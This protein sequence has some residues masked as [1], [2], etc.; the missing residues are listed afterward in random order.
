[1]KKLFALLLALT[2]VLGLAACSGSGGS[3]SAAAPAAESTAAE[4][5]GGDAAASTAEGG[6]GGG[7]FT[8]SGD[9]VKIGGLINTD[10]LALWYADKMGYFEDEGVKVD[11][12]Y[13]TNGVLENEALAAG[14]VSVGFNGFAGVYALATGDYKLIGDANDGKGLAVY[15]QPD[16]P[17]VGVTGEYDPE[18]PDVLGNA[19]T[20]SGL[21]FAVTL[22]TIQQ[23]MVDAYYQHLGV[24]DY[25]LVSMDNA[26]AFNA[27]MAGE[28]DGAAL[29]MNMVFEAEL[30]GMK[31]L[32][33][34]EDITGVGTGSSTIIPTSYLES[35]YND[36]VLVTRAFY[37]ALDELQKDETLMFDEGMA[38]FKEM[39][40][41]YTED[42]MNL[43]IETRDLFTY[44]YMENDLEFGNHVVYSAMKLVDL[45]L[46][47]PG[48]GQIV[49]DSIDAKVLEDALGFPI[50][51]VVPDGYA[52]Y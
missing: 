37:R 33:T 17:V 38:Y 14:E 52:D 39:G 36:V 4:S 7:E 10:G 15:V 40:A 8:A 43:E 34:Y 25:E 31:L 9:T 47:E 18:F 27:L 16:C 46:L 26:S 2:M 11:I 24:T 20:A 51:V 28:V 1:M 49:Y 13:F 42:Q 21:K 23:I 19:E 32:G 45:G 29:T 44:E 48:A 12:A 22:G 30:Q 5:T 35:N 3:S 41:E 50:N 6:E